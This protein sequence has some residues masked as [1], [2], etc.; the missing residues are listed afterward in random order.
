[1]TTFVKTAATL[2]AHQTICADEAEAEALLDRLARPGGRCVT[3]AFLNAKAV[4][5]AER[6]PEFYEALIRSDVL[7]RD[8]AGIEMLMTA[9]GRAPGMNMNGTDFIPRLIDAT[10]R[11][12]K[13]ALLGT[14]EPRL[15]LAAERIGAMGFGDIVNADG[16]RP[17]ADYVALVR[18]AK[19][20]LVI[21]AMGMPKQE[22]VALAL[23]QDPRLAGHRMVV[24]NGGAILDFLS[25][26]VP[27][28]P[29]WIRRARLEWL[30]RLMRE[31]FRMFPRF[32]DSLAFALHT[33]RHG[34]ALRD[35]LAEIEE[36]TLQ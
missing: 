33:R 3:L 25:G 34:P 19:P 1:M 4:M 9:A 32:C 31:P 12:A 23:S 17:E 27:R 16:F 21:L 8:G 10:P 26:D 5:Q 11:T 7:L 20:D 2:V 24:V 14:R 15:G 6:D 29:R 28:A 13:L 18:A 36:R 22:R 35:A 30:Y